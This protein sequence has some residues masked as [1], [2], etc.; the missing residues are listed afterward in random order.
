MP[1]K[2]VVGR[3]AEDH[4]D[5]RLLFHPLRAVAFFL[6]LQE[7]QRLGR[8]RLPPGER[9]GE[10]D[11]RALHPVI[12]KRS[13]EVLHGEP[14]LQMSNHE[15]SRH[16]LES[17]YA[18]RRRLLHPRAREGAETPA[19]EIAGDAAQHFCE[20]RACTA[21]RVEHVDVFR[22]EAVGDAEVV[23][24]RLVN[25][26]DHVAHHFRWRVP[27]AQLLPKLGVE[28]FEERLV[29][30]RHRL[31]LVEAGEERGPVHSVEGGRGPVQHFDQAEGLQAAGI[32]K[33]LEQRPQ[34]WRAQM[35]DR[36]M[37]VEIAGRRREVAAP[38]TPRRRRRR[39][40]AF[41]PGSS[42]R[43]ARPSRPRS[44]RQ[45]PLRGPTAPP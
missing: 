10:E 42:G 38:T 13:V 20:I 5:G 44:A 28:G 23:L 24:Q 19:F 39:R 25:A 27:D 22:G 8:S 45:G 7:R 14:H 29:E 41:A 26:S 11:L 3:V 34:N 15:G 12:R 17:E 37:P 21:A 2:A 32:G 4:Q 1:A 30:V 35:P 33:L 16:D 18:L 36:F 31:A 43:S 6:Q 9:V 40:R